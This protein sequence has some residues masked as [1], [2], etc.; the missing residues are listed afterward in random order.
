MVDRNKK[1]KATD[2]SNNLSHTMLY[3]SR[4][5]GTGHDFTKRVLNLWESFSLLVI[6]SGKYKYLHEDNSP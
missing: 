3:F 6:L 2:I 1:R 4:Y 5:A